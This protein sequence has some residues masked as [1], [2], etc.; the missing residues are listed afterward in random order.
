MFGFWYSCFWVLDGPMNQLYPNIVLT[1]DFLSA[2]INRDA[3][4]RIYCTCKA[5]ARAEWRTQSL[6]LAHFRRTKLIAWFRDLAMS[7]NV[8][9]RELWALIKSH[10]RLRVDA[11]FRTFYLF[12]LTHQHRRPVLHPL[13]HPPAAAAREVDRGALIHSENW[14]EKWHISYIT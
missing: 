12:S 9:S 14:L 11:A 13:I 1:W 8:V 5:G 10:G 2:L 4:A 3:L 7:T 6:G